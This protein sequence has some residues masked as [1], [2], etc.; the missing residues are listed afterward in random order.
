MARP[1]SPASRRIADWSWLPLA[2]DGVPTQTSEISLPQTAWRTSVVT[3][4]RPLADDVGHQLDH[5]FLDDRRLPGA[6]ELELGGIDV[7]TDRGR[8]PSRARQARETAPT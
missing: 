8:W 3:A 2:A 1:T 7:D 6:D 4:T 5:A